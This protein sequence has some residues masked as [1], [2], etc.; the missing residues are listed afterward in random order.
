MSR[1]YQLLALL[2]LIGPEP[3]KSARNLVAAP[4]S[5]VTAVS[6]NE[7][8]FVASESKGGSQVL[9]AERP[10]SKEII[11]VVLAVLEIELNGFG[12]RFRFAN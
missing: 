5:A 3:A 1:E 10:V 2:D 4:S 11:Q 8:V 6:H 7:L 12:V 9:I